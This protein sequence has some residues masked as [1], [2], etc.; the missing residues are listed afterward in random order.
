MAVWRLKL[1]Q[2]RPEEV[3]EKAVSTTRSVLV[4]DLKKKLR[5]RRS[6]RLAV[7]VVQLME[8]VPPKEWDAFTLFCLFAHLQVKKA[9]VAGLGEHRWRSFTDSGTEEQIKELVEKIGIEPAMMAIKA[10]NSPKLSWVET[11]L[12]GF[13]LR[14]STFSRFVLPA[15]LANKAKQRSGEQS[16]WLQGRGAS[17]GCEE[18]EI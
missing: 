13:A 9:S 5:S 6:Y 18:V 8:G 14:D 1:R 10:L 15:M 12:I 2:P 4:R 16:E 17:K 11:D 3:A 7:K